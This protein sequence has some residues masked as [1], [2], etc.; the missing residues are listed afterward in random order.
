MKIKRDERL[1]ESLKLLFKK[2]SKSH[3][4]EDVCAKLDRGPRVVKA[5]IDHLIAEGHNI[6]VTA[7]GFKLEARVH[8][9]S[10]EPV[11]IKHDLKH[12]TTQGVA[13]K[14][15][16]CSD[17][18]AGSLHERNDVL[19]SLYDIY[20]KEGVTEVFHC[21]NMIEGEARFN[22][23]DIKVFGM[24]DQIDHLINIYPKRKGIVTHFVAGDDHEG[25]Y[26]QR[27]RIII[28]KHIQRKFEEVGRTDFQYMGYMEGHVRFQTE[29]GGADMLVMHPGGGAAYAT[30][31]APQ[32]IAEA[33]QEGEKP[34]IC[35]MGHYHKMDYA[36][37]RGIHMVQAGCC[38]DQSTFCRKNKI[39]VVVGGVLVELH[40]APDGRINRFKPE[41]FQYFDR[42]FYG[43][44]RRKWLQ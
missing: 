8:T 13:R 24:D 15:G 5:A 31:Y 36:I 25:W 2:G 28:G 18:H 40:Q 19:E 35:L 27:T 33:F 34:Q 3:T 29:G 14:F 7:K 6:V 17:N 30:S 43:D 4:L 41:F 44:N 11:M 16:V 37:H 42:K 23:S 22:Y 32:K 20:E 38:Q 12:Y 9:G 26:Q 10:S 1:E 39:K 21:G